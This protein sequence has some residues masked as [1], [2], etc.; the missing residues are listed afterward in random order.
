VCSLLRACSP[1]NADAFLDSWD[2]LVAFKAAGKA[3]SIGKSL[4][5]MSL[6]SLSILSFCDGPTA[7]FGLHI[8]GVS[9]FGVSQL[10]KLAAHSTIV[11]SVNQV[12]FKL[13]ICILQFYFPEFQ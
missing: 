10:D 1:G 3:H 2:A 7:V 4:L 13:V 8:P 5:Y 9:N 6:L 11:P 12:Y